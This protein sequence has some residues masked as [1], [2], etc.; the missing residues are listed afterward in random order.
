METY[1]SKNRPLAVKVIGWAAMIFGAWLLLGSLIAIVG[2]GLNGP[3]PEDLFDEM[4]N[5]FPV[6]VFMGRHY[7]FLAVLQ[8][9]VACL[10]ILSGRNLLRLAGW[11]R[12]M[13]V[14]LNWCIIGFL[15]VVGLQLLS[16]PFDQITVFG[17]I[18]SLICTA[19]FG[20]TIYYLNKVGVR[21]A[22]GIGG[23]TDCNQK[24]L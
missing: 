3:P 14:A 16:G 12:G 22:F 1:S 4:T 17:L 7:T 9:V 5:R 21:L 15:V 19:P 24:Q 13:L 11:A 6:F 23:P 2:F 20:C 18:S 8:L 10:I